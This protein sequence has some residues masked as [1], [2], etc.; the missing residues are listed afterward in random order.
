MVLM[1]TAISCHKIAKFR[2][3]FTYELIKQIVINDETLDRHL[4]RVSDSFTFPVEKA[5]SFLHVVSVR[6]LQM[7][8][9]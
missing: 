1:Q 2:R 5:F 4:F 8:L 7:K 3:V 9:Y 6:W